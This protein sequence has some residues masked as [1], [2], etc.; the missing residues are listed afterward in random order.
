[1][2]NVQDL[3]ASTTAAERARHQELWSDTI[4]AVRCALDEIWKKYPD[5]MPEKF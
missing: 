5:L 2:Q 1:M 3:R 4:M